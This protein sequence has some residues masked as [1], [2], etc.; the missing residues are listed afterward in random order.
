[1][2]EQSNEFITA[3]QTKYN[4]FLQILADNEE[5]SVLAVPPAG[6]FTKRGITLDETLVS[7]HVLQLCSFDGK[8]MTSLAGKTYSMP[9]DNMLQLFDETRGGSSNTT[10]VK[11]VIRSNDSYFAGNDKSFKRIF[12]SNCLD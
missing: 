1:M 9:A 11:V 7:E 4:H 2:T 3:L 10:K 6:F 5:E 8:E 12:I